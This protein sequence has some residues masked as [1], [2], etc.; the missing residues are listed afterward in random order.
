MRD[1]K[2]AYDGMVVVALLSL[3]GSEI[4]LNAGSVFA[5]ATEAEILDER[6]TP[7]SWIGAG[8]IMIGMYVVLAFS[9]AEQPNLVSV[10]S[11]REAH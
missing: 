2:H 7:R 3:A 11:V 8:L 1:G 4:I 9:P 5:A 6:L 10:E